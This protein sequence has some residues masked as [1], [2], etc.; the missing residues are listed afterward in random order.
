MANFIATLLGRGLGAKA[1]SNAIAFRPREEMSPEQLFGCLLSANFALLMR[2][3]FNQL[4]S[5]LSERRMRKTLAEHWGIV[6]QLKC[7]RAIESGLAR[8]GEMSAPEKR[9]I[10][11]WFQGGQ[12]ES[13]EY[14]ALEHTCMS[15]VLGARISRVDELRHDHLSVIAWD[16]QQLAYLVRL[17]YALDYVSKDL[18]EAV[19]VRLRLRAR[20][21]YNSWHDYSL[22]ALV[23]LG[24][25]GSPEVFD[26]STWGRFARTHE[27]FLDARRSPISIAS[28]WAD[29]SSRSER[30]GPS[31][32]FAAVAT[33]D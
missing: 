28:R 14:A 18:A 3:N 23:G 16:I 15:M 13:N 19:L 17:A 11:A 5:A 10:A 32:R 21:H 33:A 12:L 31:P 6:S 29:E 25:R 9:A 24:L 1:W 4:G 30:V 20:S 26:S 22:S 27:V 8:V 7:R 2:D